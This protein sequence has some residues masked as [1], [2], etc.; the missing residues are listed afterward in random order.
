MA[1]YAFDGTG[2]R[3]DRPELESAE[4]T[5]VARFFFA[6]RP[7]DVDL[8]IDDRHNHYQR[9]VGSAGL[10]RNVLGKITGFGGRT[11]VRRALDKLKQNIED[12][13]DVVDVV[14]FSRGAALALDFVNE[15]AKGKVKLKD[16]SIPTV[17]FLGLFDCV[18]SFGIPISPLN[19]GWDLDLP[20]NVARC[21]HALALDE[22]RSNFHL[23]RPKV[24]GEVQK[25]RLT[26]VWFRGVHSDVGGSGAKEEPPRG[27]AGIALNW[28]FVNAQ[29]CGVKFDPALVAANKAAV[30]A[31]ARMLDNFDPIEMSFRRLRDDDFVHETVTLR[32]GCNNPAGTCAV[33][34]DTGE[35]RGTFGAPLGQAGV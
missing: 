29:A 4:D 20:P 3:D 12:Q 26:E 19:I 32:E 5:N 7:S 15:I 31:A 2:Q 35:P 24:L 22:R 16:G 6:Y 21:F 9:G 28:M 11:F 13:D 18:P 1:L 27:L 8:P 25:G 23:H 14:G 33:V 17:R 34:S 10:L 30:N